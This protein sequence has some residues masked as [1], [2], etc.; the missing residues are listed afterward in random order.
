MANQISVAEVSRQS[1]SGSLAGM[2][3]N[4]KKA[5]TEL[6]V[7]FLL[8]ERNMYINEI[9]AELSRR[10]EEQF[11]IVF[12]YAVIYRMVRFGYISETHKQKAPDGRL[13]QYYGIT[14]EGSA[15]LQEL[16]AFY[17][18]FSDGVGKI[19]LSAEDPS[20]GGVILSRRT[21]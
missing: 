19:L 12:P 21:S 17:L 5:I 11:Q 13:R 15:Y 9:T 4:F 2:E 1:R 8:D 14:P 3:N 10:S 18:K 20:Q 7:L 16:L 6:L